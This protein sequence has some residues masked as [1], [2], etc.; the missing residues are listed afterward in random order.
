MLVWRLTRERYRGLDGEGA[1]LYG[2]RWHSEGVAILYASSTLAL[3]A[4]EYLVHVD[5][6]NAPPDLVALHIRVPESAAAERISS[7][8]LPPDWARVADH[9]EC[10]R[11]GDR[12][13]REEGSAVLYVPSAIV[14]DEDNLLIHPRRL[15]SD[16][17]EVVASRRFSFDPRLLT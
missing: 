10:V 3:A 12:W 2:G 15:P 8:D 6:L 1:R 17:L 13:A 11:R 9:P 7:G 16:A 4:L 14:P 5:P